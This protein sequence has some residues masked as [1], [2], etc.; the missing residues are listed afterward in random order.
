M[1]VLRCSVPTIP[2]EEN[3]Q[4]GNNPGFQPLT[5][6]SYATVFQP[7]ALA[8]DLALAAKPRPKA[9]KEVLFLL[10]FILKMQVSLGER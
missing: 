1:L 3:P 9:S 7:E 4:S 10:H 8:R 6:H 5:T 2:N